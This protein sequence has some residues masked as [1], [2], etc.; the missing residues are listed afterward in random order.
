[1]RRAPQNRPES[2][3]STT[4]SAIDGEKR[5]ESKQIIKN[6]NNKQKTPK[7]TQKTPKP[8]HNIKKRISALAL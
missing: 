1:M 7:N 2:T 6:N 8:K 5:E 4:N 3:F